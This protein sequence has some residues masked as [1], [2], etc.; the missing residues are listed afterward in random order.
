MG[1]MRFEGNF[2]EKNGKIVKD[3]GKLE[4]D[5]CEKKTHGIILETWKLGSTHS[6]LVSFRWSSCFL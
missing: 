5:F 1:R 6:T 3:V 4:T 2:F